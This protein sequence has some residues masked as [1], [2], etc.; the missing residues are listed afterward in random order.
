MGQH[1]SRSGTGDLNTVPG[2]VRF[3]ARE[4]TPPPPSPPSP[5]PPP[6]PHRTDPGQ[7]PTH[8][9]LPIPGAGGGEPDSS[10]ERRRS[11]IYSTIDMVPQMDFYA[12]SLSQAGPCRPT[13][14]TLR[15][16]TL[17]QVSL[18]T[19]IGNELQLSAAAK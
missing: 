3:T 2:V 1:V 9:S 15:R 12:N 19:L 13:L 16:P 4:D 7:N 8:S 11:S 6:P 5:P 10:Q 17:F 18:H 14:K